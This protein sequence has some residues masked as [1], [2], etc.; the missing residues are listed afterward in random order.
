MDELP[1]EEKRESL[2]DAGNT[3]S[4]GSVGSFLGYEWTHRHSIRAAVVGTVEPH[5]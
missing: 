4:C 3:G 5:Q 2:V 1:Y